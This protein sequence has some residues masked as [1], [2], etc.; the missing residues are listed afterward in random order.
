MPLMKTVTLSATFDGT[1]IRLEEDYPLPRNARLLV[2]VLP[3][4]ATESEDEFRRTWD[5]LSAESLASAFGPEEPEYTFD[6]LK[7]LNPSYEAR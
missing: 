4:T 2:T 3:L 7:E 5:W 6:M 1:H